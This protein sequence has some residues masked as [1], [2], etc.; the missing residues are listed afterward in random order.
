MEWLMY[1]LK[2]SAC[3][4]LFFAFYLLIFRKLTFFKFNRFYLLGSL[5]LSFVIPDLQFEIKR[6]IIVTETNILTNVPKIRPGS[7]QAFQLIRPMVVEHQLQNR[8]EPDWDK[9]GFYIYGGI[10]SMLFLVCSWRLFDL[11]KH[12]RHYV[13]TSDGLKLITKT[14]GFTNCSFFNYV[15]IDE[16]KMS[17]SELQVLLAHEKVHAQQ[18]HSV[19]KI[20]LMIFKAMLWFNPI[21]YLFDKALEQTHEYEADE[22][23]SINIGNQYYASLLLRLAVSKSDMPLIHHFVKSPIK[24]RIKMLFNPKSKNMKKLMYLLALPVAF[25][26]V[27]LFAVEV[28][29]AQKKSNVQIE[30]KAMYP[31]VSDV[32]K[33]RTKKAIKK[34]T[35]NKMLIKADPSNQAKAL[36]PKILSF[37]KI[38]GDIKNKISYMQG[39]IMEI[40][41]DILKAQDV[42]FNQINN[43]ITAKGASF[44]T[45]GKIETGDKM[46]F[47]LNKNTHVTFKPIELEI[48]NKM[49]LDPKVNYRADSVK[50]NKNKTMVYMF[51]NAEMSYSQTTL[52]GT[53]IVYD[54][55][56]QSV[57]A[58]DAEIFLNH[59]KGIKADSIFYDLKTSKVKLFGANLDR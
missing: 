44:E 27:W 56:T 7:N 51:G 16:K 35:K 24:D 23:T 47:D 14:E 20:L 15:F 21:V 58:N 29:Y 57:K 4:V 43:T 30:L 49:E 5:F 17:N 12:T 19:D 50:F 3:T 37:Q 42:E 54:A 39:A 33:E 52:S 22:I 10:T 48:K 9:L 45:N 1:L 34:S 46:I 26:L 59:K 32:R 25:G 8:P 31:Q 55:L 6:E 18:Y 53:N 38:T 13:K 11:L 40:G 41:G 2:V 28:V 36:V